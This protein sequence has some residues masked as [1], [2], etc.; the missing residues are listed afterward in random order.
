MKQ[1]ALGRGVGIREGYNFLKLPLLIKRMPR[2]IPDEA[3]LK[4][5][6]LGFSGREKANSNRKT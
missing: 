5:V 3:Q 4:V 1:I 2:G 6:L